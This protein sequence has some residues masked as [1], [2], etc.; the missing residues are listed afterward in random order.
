[1]PN[2]IVLIPFAEKA[3]FDDLIGVRGGVTLPELENLEPFKNNLL[4][5]KTTYEDLVELIK[6]KG[7][8]TNISV[9]KN[10]SNPKIKEIGATLELHK[11]NYDKAQ[12][13][14]DTVQRYRDSVTVRGWNK[15][16][17]MDV[18]CADSKILAVALA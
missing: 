4:R 11:S 17:P 8:S 14:V 12:L 16:N 5:S 7:F 13:A 15:I 10:N 1:M 6:E 3:S 18:V 9:L 2:R